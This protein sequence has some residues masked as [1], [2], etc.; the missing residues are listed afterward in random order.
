ME[1]GTIIALEV[2]LEFLE[3]VQ[4]KLV[5]LSKKEALDSD[6][7]ELIDLAETLGSDVIVWLDMIIKDE[8]R[9]KPLPKG[10]VEK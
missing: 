9:K 2:Y 5:E 6:K 10:T 1:Q 8:N 4:E 7:Q 3:L